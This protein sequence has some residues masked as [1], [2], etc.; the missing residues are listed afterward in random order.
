MKRLAIILLIFS[1]LT[2]AQ[3]VAEEAIHQPLRRA[4]CENAGLS[5]NDNAN[6]CDVI[7]DGTKAELEKTPSS[8]GQP[9]T[10][11]GCNQAGMHWNDSANVCDEKA[12]EETSQI[13]ANAKPPTVSEVLITIDKAAQRM[14]VSV[15]EEEQYAWPVSTGLP[16]YS[17]PSGSY[18]ARSMNKIWYSR[19]WDNAPMPHAIFFTSDGH[20]IHGTN[21]AKRLGKPASHGCVRLSQQN[22][23]TLYTLVA[24]K[25]L[26]NTEIILTGTTPGHDAYL[27][28]SSAQKSENRAERSANSLAPTDGSNA[29]SKQRKGGFFKRLF[30]RR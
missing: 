15:D 28:R 24:D 16:R 25:G 4:D 1:S 21:E 13:E 14:T 9:L 3:A 10:R 20:A 17:T 27:A 26:E 7:G 6:V 12:E 29:R 30:G 23:A 19:E 5:W 22:A 2:A 8:T 18:T 11:I